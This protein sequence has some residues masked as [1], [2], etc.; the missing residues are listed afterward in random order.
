MLAPDDYGMLHPNGATSGQM[1]YNVFRLYKIGGVLGD[2]IMP[3]DCI[4]LRL[5]SSTVEAG[6]PWMT[7]QQA[8]RYTLSPVLFRGGIPEPQANECF[9]LHKPVD[10]QDF[11][12]EYDDVHN[13]VVAQVALTGNAL[14]GGH[15]IRLESPD[16]ED[17]FPTV[18]IL[19]TNS[20]FITIKLKE[21]ASVLSPVSRRRIAI[22][23]SFKTTGTVREEPLL[24]EGD[25]VYFMGMEI[26]KIRKLR[27]NGHK[28]RLFE[29]EAAL[30]L[31]PFDRRLGP[32]NL[33][34][35]V[36]LCSGDGGTRNL[37]QAWTRLSYDH[38]IP[39]RFT[40]EQ[41]QGEEPS[42]GTITAQYYLNGIE[43]CSHFGIK[44][45]RKGIVLDPR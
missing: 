37:T 5:L 23:A 24:L 22:R 35:I 34:L 3:G 40:V 9:E 44:I 38:A 8:R 31:D 45:S 10:L 7:I 13:E 20:P 15:T 39:F 2:P 27:S 11:V 26:Q 19:M 28:S 14:P 16:G 41:P 18:D 17:L 1:G 33:P 42:L 6:A 12:V 30:S 4:A 32:T 43:R 25:R 21:A 36:N 29:V